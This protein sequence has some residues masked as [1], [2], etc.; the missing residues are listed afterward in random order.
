[1]VWQNLLNSTE[2]KTT[3][4]CLPETD[5]D[6]LKNLPMLDKVFVGLV[7]GYISTGIRDGSQIDFVTDQV[8]ALIETNPVTAWQI[9]FPTDRNELKQKIIQP[10]YD[11]K[12]AEI[13]SQKK[14]DHDDRPQF[15]LMP[16][17]L[18]GG[19][20]I[21]SQNQHVMS[22]DVNGYAKGLNDTIAKTVATSYAA[23]VTMFLGG[24]AVEA[25]APLVKGGAQWLLNVCLANPETTFSLGTGVFEGF[26][27]SY[28][29]ES[30]ELPAEDIASAIGGLAGKGLGSILK[31]E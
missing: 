14:V 13:E 12:A 6:P 5:A 26:L 1:M 23:V 17:T 8:F 30:T 9:G 22:H 11:A 27:E 28:F 18:S 31:T 4:I 24:A 15:R 21:D 7:N 10:Y 16:G 19:I 3:G 29:N 2:N 20:Y 25:A